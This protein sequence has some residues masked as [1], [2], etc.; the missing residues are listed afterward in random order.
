MSDLRKTLILGTDGKFVEGRLRDVK[1][2]DIFQLYEP[3][4]TIVT[5]ASGSSTFLAVGD[6]YEKE[7]DAEFTGGEPEVRWTVNAA[8]FKVPPMGDAE[9]LS[10]I[11]V[12]LE[13]TIEMNGWDNFWNRLKGLPVSKFIG[14]L[15]EALRERLPDCQ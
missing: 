13:Q 10:N 1:E 7:F 3:D 15:K 4:D 14:P 12:L 9:E 11:V 5:D 2:G 6:A 8:N